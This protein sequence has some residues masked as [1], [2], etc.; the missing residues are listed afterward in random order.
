M[1]TL[2]RAYATEA[3]AHA[4]ADRLLAA[5][6]PGADIRVLMG[7]PERD[8]RE[9]P[10]GEFGGDPVGAHAPVGAFAGSG[11]DR[12][13]GM[14]GFAGSAETMRQGAFAD[15]DRDTVTT[16]PGG[17]ERVRIAAHR[18]LKALLLQAGLDEAAA[19]ADVQALH[20]GRVLVLVTAGAEC[21]AA[22]KAALDAA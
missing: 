4:A 1:P 11:P 21:E 9:A 12:A 17:V 18:G 7:E 8:T 15:A 14:G 10:A 16:Y 19:D 5:G 20:R 13:A 22:A 6:L 2:C 3:D